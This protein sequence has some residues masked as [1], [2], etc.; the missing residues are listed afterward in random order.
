MR[1]R[2][3]ELDEA[4]TALRRALDLDPSATAEP[5]LRAAAADLE[6]AASRAGRAQLA[7]EVREARRRLGD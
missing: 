6:G 5:A 1:L 2:A 4:W 7:A 3:G